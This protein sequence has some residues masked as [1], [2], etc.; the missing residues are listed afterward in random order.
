[1]SARPLSVSHFPMLKRNKALSCIVATVL[2]V[3]FSGSILEF[4]KSLVAGCFLLHQGN[5]RLFGNGNN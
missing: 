4:S 3:L 5:L 1:M 2:T